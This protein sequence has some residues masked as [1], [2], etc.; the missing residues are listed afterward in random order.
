MSLSVTPFSCQNQVSATQFNLSQLLANPDKSALQAFRQ[1]DEKTRRTLFDEFFA[2]PQA[3]PRFLQGIEKI[4]DSASEAV[5]DKV[6][7]IQLLL[8]S[9]SN[10]TLAVDLS[11]NLKWTTLQGFLCLID[12]AQA[13][14][15]FLN[16]NRETLKRVTPQ[17]IQTVARFIACYHADNPSVAV[18]W[19]KALLPLKAT[20][21]EKVTLFNQLIS[22]MDAKQTLRFL[23]SLSTCYPQGLPYFP[24]ALPE[25]MFKIFIEGRDDEDSISNPSHKTWLLKSCTFGPSTPLK[26]IAELLARQGR[27]IELHETVLDLGETDSTFLRRCQDLS[28]LF[29]P[30]PENFRDFI[31][32]N[33]LPLPLYLLT[34]SMFLDAKTGIPSFMLKCLPFFVT[35]KQLQAIGRN[36]SFEQFQSVLNNSHPP[37]LAE[38]I[39]FLI[40][41]LPLETMLAYCDDQKEKMKAVVREYLS[42]ELSLTQIYTDISFDR[43]VLDSIEG[44]AYLNAKEI[45]EKEKIVNPLYEKCLAFFPPYLAALRS[46]VETLGQEEKFADYFKLY[47]EICEKRHILETSYLKN[48]QRLKKH[49]PAAEEEV[50]ETLNDPEFYE[51]FTNSTA[52]L[53]GASNIQQLLNS[54]KAV[55]ITGNEDLKA[56]GY[57]KKRQNILAKIPR[58]FLNAS[59][60]FKDLPTWLCTSFYSDLQLNKSIKENLLRLDN[61]HKKSLEDQLTPILQSLE[62]FDQKHP[63]PITP[64]M[65]IDASLSLPINEVVIKALSAYYSGAVQLLLYRYLKQEELASS[66][67]KLNEANVFLLSELKKQIDQTNPFNLQG[68]FKT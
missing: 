6:R 26:E 14:E 29:Q 27:L 57:S 5:E 58:A 19:L 38:Q 17:E 62:E 43:M 13:A 40:D 8:S 4:V 51:I 15:A 35:K 32:E 25:G 18:L 65:L 61:G 33:F 49:G 34:L 63:L 55:G 37:L 60:S 20:V 9:L 1:L 64:C 23:E 67:Q 22:A 28:L 24:C 50:E 59:F 16:G 53:L 21:E 66:W 2:D 44:P 3:G 46:R 10:L 30:D 12:D 54:M 48:F 47:R 31:V 45:D 52:S 39:E 68:I 41:S 11:R 56:L 36:L 7:S 42:S